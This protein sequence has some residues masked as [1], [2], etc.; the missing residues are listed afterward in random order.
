MSDY[1]DEFNRFQEEKKQNE[2][3][4]VKK[5]KKEKGSVGK[6]FAA[7][8]LGFVFGAAAVVAFKGS[9]DVR[10]RAI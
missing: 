10:K 2:E 6:F 5:E 4:Q 1:N 7:V 3:K 8:F 9:E